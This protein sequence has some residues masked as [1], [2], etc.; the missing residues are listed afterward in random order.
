MGN[1]SSAI[2]SELMGNRV[3]QVKPTEQ[4]V[5]RAGQIDRVDSHVPMEC[6]CPAPSPALQAEVANASRATEAPANAALAP[7]PGKENNP[8]PAPE[9]SSA[10]QPNSSQTLSS[11]SEI[12]P[13]PP[14]QPNDV[15]VEVE[16]PFVFRG[17]KKSSA[18][19]PA[20]PEAS[21]LPVM[22]ATGAPPQLEPTVQPPTVISAAPPAAPEASVPRRVLR[23][24]RGFFAAIFR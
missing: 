17:K 5:F 3:Y 8:G 13:L 19:P 22:I 4:V 15:H 21:D 18:E 11:G 10:L 2:V 9:N 14:S 24:I 16:A 7:D 1:T 20:A 23:K 6:G 12:Q